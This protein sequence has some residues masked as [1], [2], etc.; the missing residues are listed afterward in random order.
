MG[1]NY[2]NAVPV[3]LQMAAVR[4]LLGLDPLYIANEGKLIAICAVTD[5]ENPLA[6]MRVHSLGQSA[7]IIGEVIAD[8]HQLVQ[9]ET[10]FG[11]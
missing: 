7:A 3:C 11:G 1:C 5:A 9:M 4:E 6:V 8:D 2:E 10:A